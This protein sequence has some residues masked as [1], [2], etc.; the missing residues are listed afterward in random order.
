MTRRNG[1]RSRTKASRLHRG[2]RR[3]MVFDADLLDPKR[4]GEPD[5]NRLRPVLAVQFRD[6][7]LWWLSGRDRKWHN[8]EA[9]TGKRVKLKG[10]LMDAEWY[11]RA[12]ELVREAQGGNR[13]FHAA[14]APRWRRAR[15]RAGVTAGNGGSHAEARPEAMRRKSRRDI[16]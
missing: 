8:A 3:C 4:D 1:L 10:R 12:F 13:G 16:N 9:E 11:E 2:R 5:A 6:G 7:A 15:C 14:Y